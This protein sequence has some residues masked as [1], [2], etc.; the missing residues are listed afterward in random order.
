MSLMR[1]ARLR[2]LIDTPV[3]VRRSPSDGPTAAAPAAPSTRDSTD[4][5]EA[6]LSPA[7]SR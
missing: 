6:P 4:A 7:P 1:R 3:D 2:E 5:A